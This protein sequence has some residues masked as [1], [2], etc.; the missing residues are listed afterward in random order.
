VLL[1]FLA[2]GIA[3]VAAYYSWRRRSAPG[4]A[5]LALV[6]LLVAVV[7]GGMALEMGGRTLALLMMAHKIQ[8]IALCFIPLLWLQFVLAYTDHWRHLTPKV[9][10]GLGIMTCITVVIILTT[11]YHGWFYRKIGLKSQADFILLRWEPGPWYW[12]YTVYLY[13]LMSLGCWVLIRKLIHLPRPYEGQT[14][15]L[16]IA[17]GLPIVIGLLYVVDVLPNTCLL[18]IVAFAVSG[19]ALSWGLFRYR[20]L[21]IAPVAYEAVFE[22]MS[23][24]IIV[25]DIRRQ[26]VDLNPAAQRL[27]GKRADEVIGEE[28]E[29][30]IAFLPDLLRACDGD[31][32]S[33]TKIT[34]GEAEA[35]AEDV[36]ASSASN[37]S[38]AAAVGSYDVRCSALY[39][40]RHRLTGH[41]IVLRDITA[42]EA[43][44]RAAQAAD[45]AKSELVS[46]VSHELRTPLT[47]IKLYLNLLERGAAERRPAYLQ[48]IQR[49][50]ERLQDLIEDLLHVSR[51]DLGKIKPE[52]AS[53]DLNALVR[54]LADDRRMLFAKSDLDLRLELD[55][56]LAPVRADPKLLEQVVT[57]LLSNALNYTPEG[58]VT[59]RTAQIHADG[60]SWATVAVID[61]GLGI[62][63]AERD[64]LFERFYRGAASQTTRVPGTGLGLAISQE[65]MALHHG[66][67]TCDSTLGEGS[68]FTLWLP[69]GKSAS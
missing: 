38:D 40:R 55:D 4:A 24:A 2:A 68:T 44:R 39:D 33:P 7:S 51:L 48:T 60:A 26:I 17:A 10:L 43:A 66:H 47:N 22:G 23:D 67:I 36:T 41:L 12:V 5:S 1:T 69:M 16:L 54:T 19:A 25:L 65:I 13:G 11:E 9:L 49:E 61:T 18:G 35:V 20:L 52:I 8:N 64:K 30:A 14:I 27:I 62:A 58:H 42:L 57:N 53:V 15:L 45:R 50:S 56:D 3:L 6:L 21:D 28:G 34:L 63:P 31:P 59:L 46:S 32:M 29:A 37:S